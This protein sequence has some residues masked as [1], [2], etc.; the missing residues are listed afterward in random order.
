MP[1]FKILIAGFAA[2][3]VKKVFASDDDNG[4]VNEKELIDDGGDRADK[5]YDKRDG[6]TTPST[7]TMRLMVLKR[8]R[9][10]RSA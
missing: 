7:S 8:T 3:L 1:N 10:E 2:A 9:L 6:I 4:G 5:S